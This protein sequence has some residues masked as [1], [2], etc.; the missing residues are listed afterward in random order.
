MTMAK[1]KTPKAISS[2]SNVIH[3]SRAVAVGEATE[4][5]FAALLRASLNFSTKCRP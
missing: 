4:I 5:V 3:T 1:I 2:P